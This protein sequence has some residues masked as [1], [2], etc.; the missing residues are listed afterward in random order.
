LLPFVAEAVFLKFSSVLF[1][2]QPPKLGF[3]FGESVFE[4]SLVQQIQLELHITNQLAAS[5][6]EDNTPQ[7]WF[8][9]SGYSG[10]PSDL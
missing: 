9:S 3:C 4:G 5:A 2:S 7:E 10:I 8:F 1:V 6:L